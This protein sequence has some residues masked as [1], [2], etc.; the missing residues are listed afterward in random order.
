MT[1]SREKKNNAE[2][3]CESCNLEFS[4]S[5]EHKVLTRHKR[6]GTGEVEGDTADHKQYISSVIKTMSSL[7]LSVMGF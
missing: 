5:I 3:Y 7:T 4:L 2:V 1:L 6:E